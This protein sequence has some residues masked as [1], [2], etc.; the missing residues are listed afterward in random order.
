MPSV[1]WQLDIGTTLVWSDL[2]IGLI[3]R[4]GPCDSCLHLIPDYT[5]WRMHRKAVPYVSQ[6]LCKGCPSS[7]PAGSSVTAVSKNVTYT[8]ISICSTPIPPPKGRNTTENWWENC[9]FARI[10]SFAATIKNVSVS[11]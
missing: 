3:D 10:A 8:A 1:T 9:S 2:A 11:F 4:P 7:R 6:C 5:T